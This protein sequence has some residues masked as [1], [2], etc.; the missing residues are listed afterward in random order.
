[1]KAPITPP[2]NR[3]VRPGQRSRWASVAARSGMPTPANT[4]WPSSSWRALKMVSSSAAVWL[5]ALSIVNALPG[6]RRFEQLVD[7]DQT[8]KLAPR[9]RRVDEAVHVLLHPIDGILVHQR[10]VGFQVADHRLVHAVAF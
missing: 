8:E 3:M 7:P 6:A 4:S 1:M 2:S 10:D 9:F 5:W